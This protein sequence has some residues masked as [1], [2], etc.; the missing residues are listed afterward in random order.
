M[1]ALLELWERVGVAEA[2]VTTVGDGQ[3][4]FPFWGFAPDPRHLLEGG[5]LPLRL[6]LSGNHYRGM[7]L[8][9]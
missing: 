9:S 6:R 4:A 7:K 8:S 2:R 3:S 5:L 1:E